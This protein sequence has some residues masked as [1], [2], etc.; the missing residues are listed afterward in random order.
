VP[1]FEGL[2]LSFDA[3]EEAS[4]SSRPITPQCA[5]GS[6]Q[7]SAPNQVDTGFGLREAQDYQSQWPHG[8]LL[9][10]P[11]FPNHS[12]AGDV[13]TP[14]Q[15]ASIVQASNP[16]RNGRGFRI[17]YGRVLTSLILI[18]VLLSVLFLMCVNGHFGW[19]GFL[20]AI[21]SY[22]VLVA[23]MLMSI[24]TRVVNDFKELR[25]QQ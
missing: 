3:L 17:R 6:V 23:V 13:T 4:S 16:S 5:S 12:Q 19:S 8:S 11:H 1:F 18:N 7:T 22:T 14:A 25:T 10:G 21:I 9:S 15:K 24:L 2:L 20:V